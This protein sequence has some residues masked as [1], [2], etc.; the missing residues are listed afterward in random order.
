MREP[1]L[2]KSYVEI[3]IYPSE[4]QL[5]DIYK[6]KKKYISCVKGFIGSLMK[7]AIYCRF[8][9]MSHEHRTVM[10]DVVTLWGFCADV[11]MK[12]QLRCH[13]PVYLSLFYKD[14]TTVVDLL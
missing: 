12:R 8:I 10:M 14:F 11:R 4:R 2:Y 7:V 13:S 1:F 9:R 6:G 5:N 3:H